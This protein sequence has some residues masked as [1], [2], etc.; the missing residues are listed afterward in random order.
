MLLFFFFQICSNFS[1][2]WWS[3]LIFFSFINQLHITFYQI[4][5]LIKYFRFLL[6]INIIKYEICISL[7]HFPHSNNNICIMVSTHGKVALFF[8]V[9]SWTYWNCWF[10]LLL[11]IHPKKIIDCIMFFCQ[12]LFFIFFEIEL[13]VEAERWTV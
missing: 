3:F 12:L 8:S 1:I 13:N 9:R 5:F 7:H 6:Y 4:F 2:R 10:S 11:K